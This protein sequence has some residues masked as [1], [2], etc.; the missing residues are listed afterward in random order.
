ML[1]QTLPSPAAENG[2]VPV[3]EGRLLSLSDT[4]LMP[5]GPGTGITCQSTGAGRAPTAKSCLTTESDHRRPRPVLGPPTAAPRPGSPHARPAVPAAGAGML[6]PYL[7]Q[8]RREH[9]RPPAV[10]RHQAAS[11]DQSGGDGGGPPCGRAALAARGPHPGEPPPQRGSGSRRHGRSPRR[12][13]LP[14]KRRG[15]RACAVPVPRPRGG[16][17]S[18][19]V[20]PGSRRARSASGSDAAR[21]PG[22]DGAGREVTWKEGVARRGLASSPRQQ[23]IG[24]EDIVSSCARGSFGW[25]QEEFLY[26][27]GG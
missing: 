8:D 3:G 24:Q 16:G 6:L 9:A 11:P 13:H 14:G 7:S 23:A 20:P 15:G 5:R 26:S 17:D 21:T 22:G 19:P 25:Q 27:E 2:G 4:L 12:R 1:R 10:T 18:G